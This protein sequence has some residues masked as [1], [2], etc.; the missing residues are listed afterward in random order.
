MIKT[1]FIVVMFIS[2]IIVIVIGTNNAYTQLDKSKEKQENA[3]VAEVNL[4]D[5]MKFLCL[6]TDAKNGIDQMK[7][8]EQKK[9]CEEFLDKVSI[10]EIKELIDKYMEKKE[11]EN[12]TI[13]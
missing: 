7:D 11:V 13:D 12:K 3:E 5:K 4:T 9:K 1:V 10:S 6:Q 2:F 8:E